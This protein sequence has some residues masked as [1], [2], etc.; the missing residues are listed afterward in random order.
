LAGLLLLLLFRQLVW[1]CGRLLLDLSQEWFELLLLLLLVG[2]LKLSGLLLLSVLQQL[3]LA[4]AAAG[5]IPG[6]AGLL[7]LLVGP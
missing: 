5:S 6:S 7:L 4:T 3:G 2:R 1:V